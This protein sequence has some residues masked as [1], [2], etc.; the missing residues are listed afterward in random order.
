MI[1]LAVILSE[2]KNLGH[3]GREKKRQRPFA[4]LRVTTF[5]KRRHTEL[6][7]VHPCS[8]VAEKS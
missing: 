1:T 8:S 2:A 3:A 4:T 5:G 6:S 7:R